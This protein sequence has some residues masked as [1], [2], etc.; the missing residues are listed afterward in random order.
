[1]S[2]VNAAGFVVPRHRSLG[3]DAPFFIVRA[4]NA[5]GYVYLGQLSVPSEFVGKRV[6]FEMRVVG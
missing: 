1:M 2:R 4:G 3:V 5:S 6:C